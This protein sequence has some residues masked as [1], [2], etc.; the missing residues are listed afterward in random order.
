MVTGR[1]FAKDC[2]QT[3]CEA[4]AAGR[5]VVGGRSVACKVM[6]GLHEDIHR[7]SSISDLAGLAAA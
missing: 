1:I 4:P 6:H 3:V 2:L 7:S 5:R